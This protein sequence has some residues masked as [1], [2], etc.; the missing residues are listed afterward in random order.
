ML[1]LSSWEF[2]IHLCLNKS[3]KLSTL[4]WMKNCFFF[5]LTLQFLTAHLIHLSTN[6]NGNNIGVKFVA[7]V[8]QRFDWT[9]HTHKWYIHH[10]KQTNIHTY[11]HAYVKSRIYVYAYIYIR[12]CIY[13]YIYIY[14][15][16]YIPCSVLILARFW[17]V[18]NR[19]TAF[20]SWH[21]T[22]IDLTSAFV[23]EVNGVRECNFSWRNLLVTNSWFD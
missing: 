20:M 23:L 3:T 15:Y 19:E 13:I 6:D 14:V 2:D 9:W 21:G 16:I 4:I 22:N 8:E 5:C 18:N 10:I 11:A 7:K 1:F 17:F 12:V